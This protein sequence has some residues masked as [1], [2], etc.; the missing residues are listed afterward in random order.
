MMVIAGVDEAGRGPLAGPVVAAAV[1]LPPGHGLA[2][3][4]SKRLSAR[5]REQL[6]PQIRNCA[7]AWAVAL[8]SAAEIDALNIH[9]A[10]LLA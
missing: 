3:A 1:I 9:R 7:V 5:R 2:L 4:D 6:A 10:S 8:A